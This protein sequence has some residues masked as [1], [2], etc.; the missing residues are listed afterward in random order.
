MTILYDDSVEEEQHASAM[1]TLAKELR[2]PFH[3]VKLAYEDELRRIKRD[4]TV[5]DYLPLFAGR[6]AR[7]KLAAYRVHETARGASA[8][9]DL[10]VASP[11]ESK[12]AADGATV[13]QNELLEIARLTPEVAMERLGTSP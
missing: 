12:V 13:A 10:D 5:S 7:A 6:G 1:V 8:T 4:A 9:P 2:L 11:T 3:A